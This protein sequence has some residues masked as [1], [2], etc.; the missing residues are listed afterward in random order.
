[1]TNFGL[2]IGYN[3]Q[4]VK[5]V[6]NILLPLCTL[7]LCKSGISGIND[8]K[9]KILHARGI[10]HI[11]ASKTFTYITFLNLKGAKNIKSKYWLILK[12][13]KHVLHPTV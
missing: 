5:M 1:M 13:A 3:F 7:S 8:Y 10:H 12:T 6:L 4:L 9:V 11:H 2:R